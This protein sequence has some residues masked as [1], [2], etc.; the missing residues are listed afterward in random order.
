M[1]A[2]GILFTLIG[3][4][5]AVLVTLVILFFLN[6]SWQRALIAEILESDTARQWDLGQ[7][8]LS[9]RHI[10]L[11]DVYV[12]SDEFGLEMKRLQ[13]EGISWAGLLKRSLEI[14]SGAVE[15]LYLDLTKVQVGGRTSEDWQSFVRRLNEDPQLW[16]D[17]MSIGLSRIDARGWRLRL[18]DIQISGGVLLPGEQLIPVR[19]QV[20]EAD[21]KFPEDILLT[22]SPE[23][24][25]ESL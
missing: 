5:V 24:N 16:K 19:I 6:T 12:L 17:R 10:E 21:S 13:F 8:S 22:L 3:A 11:T 4:F 14:E 20:E 1:R 7:F 9:P 2:I 18:Q 25:L 15:G 23:L